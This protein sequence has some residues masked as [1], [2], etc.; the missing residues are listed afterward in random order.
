MRR[1]ALVLALGSIA[2][3]GRT[4]PGAACPAGTDE[5]TGFCICINDDGCPPGEACESDAGVCICANDLCCPN[6]YRWDPV[7]RGCACR[8]TACCPV[9]YAWDDTQAACACADSSCCPSGYTFDPIAKRCGCDSDACCP[10]GT[11]WDAG[12]QVCQCQSD[13][14]CPVGSVYD[15]DRQ[16]CTCGQTSCCPPDHTY[17]PAVKACVCTG[18]SCCPAGFQL[19]GGRCSCTSGSCAAGQVCDLDAGACRCLSNQGCPQGY[20]CNAL[21]SCQSLSGCNSDVDC[22]PGTFFCD[23]S[24]QFCTQ[25]ACTQDSQCP[26]EQICDGAKRT[27]VPGCRTT[28]DCNLR[29]SCSPQGQCQDFCL[30]NDFCDAGFFCNAQS[31]NCFDN[32]MRY[33]TNPNGTC[34]NAGACPTGSDC[35]STT[36]QG[37]L[38]YCALRCQSALD[39][40]SGFYCEPTIEQCC[41]P[42]LQN[43]LLQEGTFCSASGASGICHGFQVVDETSLIYIC[44]D[45]TTLATLVL[46]SNC[47]PVTGF[48]Q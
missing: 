45:P 12:S 20:F 41:I 30:S 21:S 28:A 24:H 46:W 38:Q 3:C 47:A 25:V 37:Q 44:A 2:C 35:L 10:T 11:A 9:A 18:A 31:G 13:S 32:G 22:P 23:V 15:L 33:C 43:C 16:N 42:Q 36:S 14:C 48:C 17:E 34:L 6:G 26:F 7:G 8:A 27:C 5:R 40:P 1:L 19:N 4:P 39:C 29:R